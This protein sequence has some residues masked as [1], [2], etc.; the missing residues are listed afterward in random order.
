ML[1]RL[2]AVEDDQRPFLTHELGQTQPAVA[3]RARGRVGVAELAQRVVDDC[4]SGT[5]VVVFQ[6]ARTRVSLMD[7]T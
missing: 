1:E 5:V 2:D 7:T 6:A 3:R 4:A